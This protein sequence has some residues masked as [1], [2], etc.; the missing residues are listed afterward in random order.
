MLNEAG[1]PPIVCIADDDAGMRGAL[2]SMLQSL[3]MQTASHGSL[4]ELMADKRHESA[5]CLLLDESLA[6]GSGLDFLAGMADRTFAPP[7]VLMIT[8]GGMAL[9]VRAMK[10]GAIDVLSKPFT[11]PQL[12]AALSASLETFKRRRRHAERAETLKRKFDILTRRER[13]VLE[14]VTAGLMNKQVAWQLGLSE[15]TVKIHRGNIMRKLQAK[16]LADLVRMVLARQ[17]EEIPESLYWTAQ[18]SRAGQHPRMK[19]D[20]GHGDYAGRHGAFLQGL[21]YGSAGCL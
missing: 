13:E 12:L 17:S 10:A 7:V 1:C 2:D 21:G 19:G 14:L 5:A 11:P 6:G 8:L 15:I 18:G 16:S 3:G 4:D 20:Y 9:A